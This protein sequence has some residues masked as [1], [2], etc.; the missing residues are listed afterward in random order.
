MNERPAPRCKRRRYRCALLARPIRMS[1]VRMLMHVLCRTSARE[2]AKHGLLRSLRSSQ[3]RVQEWSRNRCAYP[4]YK[5]HAKNGHNCRRPRGPPSPRSTAYRTEYTD[6]TL[7]APSSGNA[8]A[9]CHAAV[10]VA[11]GAVPPLGAPCASATRAGRNTRAAADA[12]NI[13]RDIFCMESSGSGQLRLRPDP[14][15]P[16]AVRTPGFWRG[17]RAR[18]GYAWPGCRS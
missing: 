18:T 16:A 8:R 14:I 5:L 10:D 4:G 13:M 9:P 2:T 3:W 11:V 15:T 1:T 12:A 7:S 17:G 6:D